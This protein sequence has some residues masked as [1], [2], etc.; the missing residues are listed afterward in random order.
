M[1][2]IGA[3]AADELPCVRVW[4]RFHMQKIIRIKMRRLIVAI[5]VS[6]VVIDAMAQRGRDAFPVRPIRIIVPYV[7]GGSATLVARFIGNRLSENLGQSVIIDNRGGGSGKIG[8]EAV[9]KATPDGYTLLFGETGSMAINVWLMDRTGSHP[10]K[11]FAAVG[12]V[13]TLENVL[14]THPSFGVKNLR[15]LV[16]KGASGPLIYGSSGTGTVGH[17]AMELL[18]K[19][20]NIKVTHVPYKG[21]SQAV[22]DLMGGQIPM[23]VVTVPTAAPYVLSGRFVAL[24]ALSQHRTAILPDVPTVAEQGFPAFSVSQWYGFFAPAGTPKKLVSFLNTEIR[25]A[26]NAPEVHKALVTTGN[27]I[28]VTTPEAFAKIVADDVERWR[29][30]IQEGGI[31]AN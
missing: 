7:A 20:L 16:S 10:I 28:A 23:L 27:E 14:V 30:V 22:A 29:A 6:L 15:E 31:Q 18:K 8:A 19:T 21:G 9:A 13:V 17:L 11:D 26:V 5:F 4:Y 25:K 24:S 3:E 12:Q 1:I 2:S